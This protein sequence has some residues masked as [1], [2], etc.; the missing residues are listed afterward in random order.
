MATS[1][2]KPRA[3]LRSRRYLKDGRGLSVSAP[4]A[5]GQANNQEQIAH[6]AEHSTN[7]HQ[8]TIANP[9]NSIIARGAGN[10]P[11]IP[12]TFGNEIGTLARLQ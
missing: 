10:W 7:I 3:G 5:R 9:G 8:E 2:L 4:A 11:A 12:R 1:A 6:V